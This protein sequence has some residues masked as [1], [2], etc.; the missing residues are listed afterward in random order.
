MFVLLLLRLIEQVL[1]ELFLLAVDLL[2]LLVFLGRSPVVP[3]NETSRIMDLIRVVASEGTSKIR[4]ILTYELLSILKVSK[5]V[6]F[7]FV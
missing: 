1:V 2:S 4:F 6:P 7:I 3:K 5:L